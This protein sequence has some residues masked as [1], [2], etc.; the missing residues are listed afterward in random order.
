MRFRLPLLT[1]LLTAPTALAFAAG[2]ENP[3]GSN[4]NTLQQVVLSFVQ[5]FLK[6]MGIILFCYFVYAGFMFVSAR[7]NPEKIEKARSAFLN[8]VIG[9][10]LILGATGITIIIQG[11]IKNTF[12]VSVP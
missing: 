1:L 5:V 8:S 3:L 10:F 9:A 2:I 11:T 7:G 12:G 6:F 4:N